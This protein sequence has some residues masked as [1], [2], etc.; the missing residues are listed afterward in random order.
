MENINHPLIGISK[1]TGE[2]KVMQPGKKYIFK[3]TKNVIE[4]PKNDRK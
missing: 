1:E 2:Q 3:N 4:L